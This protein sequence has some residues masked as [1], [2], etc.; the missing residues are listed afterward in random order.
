M[1]LVFH[2]AREHPRKA[3]ALGFVLGM[4]FQT[5]WQVLEPC[6]AILLAGL[7][8]M[9]VRDFYL[10]TEYSFD[11]DG[12]RTR[13]LLKAGRSYPWRRFRAFVEDRNGLFLSPYKE[14]CRLDQQRGVFLPMTREQRLSAVEYCQERQLVRRAA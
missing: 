2:P 10:E 13:G 9:T 6:S 4:T 7:L 5:L 3:A 11:E 14:R 12:I 8:V 1:K